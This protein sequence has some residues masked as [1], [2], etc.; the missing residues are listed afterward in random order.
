MTV[1]LPVRDV[2]AATEFYR[3]AFE[4]GEPDLIPVQ[5]LVEFDL[6]SFWLQLVAAPDRAGKRGLT[7]NISVAAA[8]DERR[9]FEAL[10]SVSDLPPVTVGR[11]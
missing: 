8:A 7:V 9:R 11:S 5:G 1:G 6:D 2:A 3:T 10:S 4:L